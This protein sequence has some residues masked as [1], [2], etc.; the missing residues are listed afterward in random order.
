M[1]KDDDEGD[2]DED[3]FWKMAK[4]FFVAY[5]DQIGKMQLLVAGDVWW[6]LS[7]GPNGDVTPHAA[8]LDPAKNPKWLDLVGLNDSGSGG[9]RCIYELDGAF[10]KNV[11]RGP[12][13]KFWTSV[14]TFGLI[15]IVL[16]IVAYLGILHIISGD[17]VA[18]LVGSVIGYL[19][20]FLKQHLIGTG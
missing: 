2:E 12:V 15:I 18:F 3:E 17:A 8:K 14:M 1:T 16:V 20:S 4:E 13:L 10:A 11:E 19:F 5:K 6:M 9:A 7:A